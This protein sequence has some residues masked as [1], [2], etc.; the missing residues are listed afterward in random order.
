MNH[1][2]KTEYEP[3]STWGQWVQQ[4]LDRKHLG[5][6]QQHQRTGISHSVIVGWLQD[7]T[8]RMGGVVAFAMGLGEDVNEALMAA[9]YDPIVTGAEVLLAGLEAF[10]ERYPDQAIPLLVLHGGKR[11]LTIADAQK[12]LADME[13]DLEA[14]RYRKADPSKES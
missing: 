4:V 7:V 14:G 9:G 6:R 11:P 2:R 1:Q 3:K 13:L 8:P 12:W 10:A 5:M